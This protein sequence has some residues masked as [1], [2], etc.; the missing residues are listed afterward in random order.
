MS[1]LV[2]TIIIVA[3]VITVAFLAS[4]GRDLLKIFKKKKK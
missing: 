1:I 3:V 4:F 2:V